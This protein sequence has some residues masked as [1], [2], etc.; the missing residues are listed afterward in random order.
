MAP[1]AGS[2]RTNG[3]RG[4]LYMTAASCME[5]PRGASKRENAC[6]CSNSHVS[7][8]S[9]DKRTWNSTAT[10]LAFAGFNLPNGDI[11]IIIDNFFSIGGIGTYLLSS[12]RIYIRQMQ[13]KAKH[14]KPTRFTI[15]RFLPESAATYAY[16]P[17]PMWFLNL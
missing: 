3:T 12:L 13:A 2:K 17:S 8:T 14:I 1:S 7:D 10:G 9:M 5:T 6:L 11:E 4:V 15:K 16:K